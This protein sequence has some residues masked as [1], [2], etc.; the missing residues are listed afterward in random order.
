MSLIVTIDD[1]IFDHR[2]QFYNFKLV[3]D[4]LII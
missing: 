1:E 3:N 4:D 2:F